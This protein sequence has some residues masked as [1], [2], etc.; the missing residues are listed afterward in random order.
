MRTRAYNTSD[1]LDKAIIS[2]TLGRHDIDH[3]LLSS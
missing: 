2:N 3:K 1:L